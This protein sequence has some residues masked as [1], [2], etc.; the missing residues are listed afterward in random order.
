MIE[1]PMINVTGGPWCSCADIFNAEVKPLTAALE[2]K[3]TE[4]KQS[5]GSTYPAGPSLVSGTWPAVQLVK[6]EEIRTEDGY[7]GESIPHLNTVSLGQGIKVAVRPSAALL[8]S[9]ITAITK[10]WGKNLEIILENTVFFFYSKAALLSTMFHALYNYFLLTIYSSTNYLSN[11][12]AC[13]K[14][15]VGTCLAIGLFILFHFT[16]IGNLLQMKWVKWTDVDVIT[17][18]VITISLTHKNFALIRSYSGTDLIVKW[19]EL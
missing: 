4:E 19:S 7:V 10:Y 2:M 9:R 14:I 12:L 17:W 3:G 15:A 6:Q 18:I 13:I 16:V 8:P 11:R 1:S 5:L